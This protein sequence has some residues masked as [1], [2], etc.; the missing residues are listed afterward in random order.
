[1]TGVEVA[2]RM[3]PAEGVLAGDWYDTVEVT[4]NRLALVLGDVAGQG[5]AS[6]VFALR[7]KASLAAALRA[8]LTPAQALGVTAAD[9]GDIAPELFA[10]ALVAVIDTATGTL[11][12]ANA[13]HPAAL[14]LT[15]EAG[16]HSG[17][18]GG[19]GAGAGL[20]RVELAP[21]GPLLSPVVAN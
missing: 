13:G 14:I 8:G 17:P 12:Y 18:G 20:S 5:P 11:T 7:L 9:L 10:T 4:Q 21:T 1:M 6:A 16:R 2:A 19:R 15:S 3:D